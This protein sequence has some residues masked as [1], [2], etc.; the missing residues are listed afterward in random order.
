[1]TD[2]VLSTAVIAGHL[3]RVREEGGSGSFV[4][5]FSNR[6]ANYYVQV[7]A[8]RGDAILHV[9]AV[10]NEYLAQDHKLRQLQ[11]ERLKALGW[12]V[13]GSANFSR[14][15]QAGTEEERLEA[16]RFIE[17]TLIQVYGATPGRALEVDL[18]LE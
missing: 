11:L 1:M 18:N 8:S 7:A 15:M 14:S 17:Q 10:N 12:S 5:F 13:G 16:A 2:D 3:R 4:I 9:E 6:D